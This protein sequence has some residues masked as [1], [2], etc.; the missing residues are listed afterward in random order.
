MFGHKAADCRKKVGNGNRAVGY[1]GNKK[2]PR[3][4]F[5]KKAI[6]CYNCGLLGHM[7]KDCH[8]PKNE[9]VDRANKTVAGQISYMVRH[10]EITEN[11]WKERARE[12]LMREDGW[13]D[14]ES[15]DEGDS[16][17]ED[18]SED[19]GDELETGDGLEDLGGPSSSRLA[20]TEPCEPPT[21]EPDVP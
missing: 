9:K 18:E 10:E 20:W 15:D 13:G 6:K 3:R 17:D 5:N 19:S 12:S 8:K 2:G 14:V 11:E 21:L 16:D 7:A 1:E 4:D